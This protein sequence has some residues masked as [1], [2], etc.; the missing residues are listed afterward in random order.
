MWGFAGVTCLYC[1]LFSHQCMKHHAHASAAPP[2]TTSRTLGPSVQYNAAEGSKSTSAQ[3]EPH[4]SGCM[5]GSHI[6]LHASSPFTQA[7]TAGASSDDDDDAED[8][9]KSQKK[10][11]DRKDKSS[12]KEK[13]SERKQKKSD[14]KEKR[15]KSEKKVDAV[16]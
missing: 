5:L 12:K 3:L 6:V 2:L 9:L 11:K 10:K 7:A 16:L 15:D 4:I 14:K 8:G 13:K 1:L